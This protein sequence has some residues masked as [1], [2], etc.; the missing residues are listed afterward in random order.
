MK[1]IPTAPR[2]IFTIVL[3]SYGD[4]CKTGI[5]QWR[6]EKKPWTLKSPCTTWWTT[7]SG[8]FT[9]SL[10]MP[11]PHHCI[12]LSAASRCPAAAISWMSTTSPRSTN[13][14]K[15]EHNH[16]AWMAN[17]F[18]F[19]HHQERRH[20]VHC[21]G[22]LIFL[23]PST[24]AGHKRKTKGKAPSGIQSFIEVIVVFVKD[25]VVKPNVGPMLRARYL[26]YPLPCSSL[27]WCQFDG[28]C[29]RLR[30]TYPETSRWQ[31]ASRF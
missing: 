21:D 19:L 29:A 8:A 26:P 5:G 13:G 2:A 3:M 27:S 30:A 22:N 20:V 15:F 18:W 11:L 31:A 12:F 9:H 6:G 1:G 28:S 25:E 17:R 14:Y 23:L 4:Q 16:I 7:T 10:V 24:A